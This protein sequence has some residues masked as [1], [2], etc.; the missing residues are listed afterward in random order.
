MCPKYTPELWYPQNIESRFWSYVEKTEDCWLWTR[1]KNRKGY[2]RF[3]ACPIA[4]GHAIVGAHRFAYEITYGPIP[5]G[6][7]VCHRCDVPSCVR[8][9]HLFLGTDRDNIQDAS[10]KGRMCHGEENHLHKLTAEQVLE[11][12]SIYAEGERSTQ[13]IGDSFGVSRAAIRLIVKRINWKHI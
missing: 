5:A 11:I 13:S 10:H 3:C 4:N 8:P 7:F 2:G 6:M 9:S 12:R 1:S